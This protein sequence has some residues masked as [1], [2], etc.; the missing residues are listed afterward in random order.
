M[1]CQVCTE[2]L[3]PAPAEVQLTQASLPIC[4]APTTSLLLRP[5]AWPAH[6]RI[7]WVFMASLLITAASLFLRMRV[8]QFTGKLY[9]DYYQSAWAPFVQAYK[10]IAWAGGLTGI[11]LSLLSVNYW[12]KSGVALSK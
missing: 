10:E 11:L 2:E 7:A 12:L 6:K 4:V 9:P 3:P 5:T 8:C 1:S